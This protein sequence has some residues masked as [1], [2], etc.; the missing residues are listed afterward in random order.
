MMKRIVTLCLG[1]LALTMSACG[2]SSTTT[3]PRTPFPRPAGFVAVNFSADDRANKVYAD[4][5]LKWKGGLSVDP[6][7]RVM[8]ADSTWGGKLPGSTV[9]MS[10]WPFLYDD[11]PWTE[12]GHEPVGAVAGDHIWG[13]TTFV[14]PSAVGGAAKSFEYGLIDVTFAA[15]GATDGNW[16][17]TGHTGNGTVAV[18]AGALTD[19]SADVTGPAH[20]FAK[21]G[22]ID[23]KVV[24]NKNTM[25]TTATWDASVV[26]FK[27]S[28]TS[29]GEKTVTCTA[30]GLCE[31]VLSN[32]AGPAQHS[33]LAVSGDK[34]EW[35]WVLGVP[36]APATSGKEYK[37][38]NGAILTGV[39]AFFKRPTDTTWQT[40]TIAQ[41]TATG[42]SKGNTY[43]TIP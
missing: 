4:G 32:F 22:D 13:I 25:D 8:T 2:S 6:T 12:G 24:L 17:W 26:K 31:F 23:V 37:D 15:A 40:A 35:V 20:T 41:V 27:G 3:T 42:L 19:G 10:A 14:A 16:V 36:V 7:T 39:T 21:Y 18:P 43:I 28:V 38:A 9:G 5:Q 11:G 33:G 29:W 34:P 1:A 30:A